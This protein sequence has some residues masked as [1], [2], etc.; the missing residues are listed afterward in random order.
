MPQ[1]GGYRTR[2]G[3]AESSLESYERLRE[4][5]YGRGSYDF[6]EAALNQLGYRA[7]QEGHH[8]VAIRIFQLNVQHF[9]ESGNV[10]D[11][12]AEAYMNNDQNKLALE[13]YRKALALN[14]NNSNAAQQIE[15]LESKQ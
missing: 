15:V 3:G 11:S 1:A 2:R 14:P 5:F 7:L 8:D 13:N 6:G 9:P 10:Y 12:L 4:D